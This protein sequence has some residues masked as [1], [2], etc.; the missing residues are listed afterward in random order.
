MILSMIMAMDKNG[1]IGANGGLPWHLPDELRYFKKVTMGRPLIMGRKTFDSIGKPLP[2]RINIVLTRQENWN[3]EGVIAVSNLEAALEVAEGYLDKSLEA[4][5]IGGASLCRETM[6]MVEKLYLTV[7]DHEFSG[8]TWLDCFNENDWHE[9]SSR[10]VDSREGLAY[11][12][13]YRV[14]V[15]KNGKK[16]LSGVED[17]PL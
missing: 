10:N 14:L 16:A 12:Y 15:R 17:A 13:K 1:L 4:M 8:D 7:I 6:P 11:S 3:H 5:V 9:L 2:G